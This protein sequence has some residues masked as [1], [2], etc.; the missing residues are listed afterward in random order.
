MKHFKCKKKAKKSFKTGKISLNDTPYCN[1][2][3]IRTLP[4]IADPQYTDCGWNIVLLSDNRFF[5]KKYRTATSQVRKL[6]HKNSRMI[7]YFFRCE[8]INKKSAH[9]R[10]RVIY[11]HSSLSVR[12]LLEVIV[13]E[14][15]HLVDHIFEFA[16]I[17]VIDTEFRA[18]LNDYYCGSIFDMIDFSST[19]SK[20]KFLTSK[21]KKKAQ[22]TKILNRNDRMSFLTKELKRKKK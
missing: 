10:T 18:Y 16:G 5:R 3:V 13:H 21:E 6:V 19:G 20:P 14:V 22:K 2:D 15:S 17:D 11:L 12:R 4:S 9:F 8:P 7:G 1:Y